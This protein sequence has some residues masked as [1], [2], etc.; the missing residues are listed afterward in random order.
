MSCSV[1]T[2]EVQPKSRGQDNVMYSQIISTESF[3][4]VQ[5]MQCN[6][7]IDSRNNNYCNVNFPVTRKLLE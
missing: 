5:R 2:K 4:A 6:A 1:I 7:E 3:L